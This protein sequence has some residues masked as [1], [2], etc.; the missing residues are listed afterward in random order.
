MAGKD[1]TDHLAHQDALVRMVKLVQGVLMDQMDYQA[2]RVNVVTMGPRVK[3]VGQGHLV[4][5]DPLGIWAE[6]ATVEILV[7]QVTP[8]LLEGMGNPEARVLADLQV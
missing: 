3:M 7:P 1:L 4:N 8:V 2:E 5:P 6:L